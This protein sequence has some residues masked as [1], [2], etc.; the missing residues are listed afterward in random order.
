ML[1]EFTPVTVSKSFAPTNSITPAVVRTK[2]I[3]KAF[4]E[5]L[6][7]EVANGAASPDTIANYKSQRKLFLQWCMD[8]QLNPLLADKQHIQQ[9]RQ[10]LIKEKNYKTA[11]IE[12]KL[13]VVRR[14]YAA[15][16]EH[17]LVDRDPAKTVKA[18]LNPRSK[19]KIQYLSIEQLQQLFALTEGNRPKLKRDRVILGLMALHGLRTL[20]VQRLSFVEQ[21]H[22][23]KA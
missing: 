2:S 10:Y 1:L 11:T 6:N 7:F 14:F 8:V 5:F 12:L 18:P 3:D 4:E 19:G 23:H 9:Y 17:K 22:H 16:I 20:E 21:K 15:L 13:Q